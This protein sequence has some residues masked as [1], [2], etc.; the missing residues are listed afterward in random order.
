[1]RSQGLLAP[2]LDQ[3][4]QALLAQ[5]LVWRAL[6]IRFSF[7]LCMMGGEPNWSR[8]RLNP[9]SCSAG[10]TDRAHGLGHAGLDAPAADHREHAG[11]CVVFD[12]SRKGYGAT[13]YYISSPAGQ[14]KDGVR[15][16]PRR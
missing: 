14:M 8:A 9:D 11:D 5:P 2:C 13:L 10:H 4:C 12:A 7:I 6:K 15:S 16:L 3:R 1:M